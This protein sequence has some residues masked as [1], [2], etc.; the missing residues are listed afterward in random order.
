[1]FRATRS[2]ALSRLSAAPES[3]SVRGGRSPPVESLTGSYKGLAATLKNDKPTATK[4]YGDIWH[5]DAPA[6]R[7]AS[8][9]TPRR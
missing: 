7:D 9:F 2:T 4:A 3:R 1:M 5:K 8:S 6:D